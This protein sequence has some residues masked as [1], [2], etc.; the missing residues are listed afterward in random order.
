[1]I[2]SREASFARLPRI[3]AWLYDRLSNSAALEKQSKD[4][5]TDLASRIR[6]GRLLDVGTGP[7]RLL[8]EIHAL[9]TDVQ[10]FGLDISPALVKKAEQNLAGIPVDLHLGSIR[11]TD[12]AN[13]YFDLITCTGSFY[14]WDQPE[15]C[16]EEIHRILKP[17]R[18]AVLYETHSQFD[19]TVFRHALKSNLRQEKLLWRLIAP[20]FLML[21]LKMTYSI[22]EMRQIVRR[23]SFA[24]HFSLERI[25]L[26]GLPI[27]IAIELRT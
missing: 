26:G 25:T 1:M 27:W 7:G 12:Y 3:G 11:H 15:R 19:A 23:T 20:R 17:Q 6:A 21:Q 5:A 9:R 16:L 10:L 22:E 18:Q 14:P 13:D 2:G 8:Q 24:D 4:V